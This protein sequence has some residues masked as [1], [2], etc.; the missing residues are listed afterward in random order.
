VIVIDLEGR[1]EDEVIDALLKADENYGDDAEYWFFP[2]E[3][4]TKYNSNSY[5]SGLFKLLGIN[6]PEVE[7]NV[8]GFDNPLPSIHFSDRTRRVITE[9]GEE[10]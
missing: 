6:P 9:G 10:W 5:I 8:P 2:K 7:S 1:D 3:G 4:D